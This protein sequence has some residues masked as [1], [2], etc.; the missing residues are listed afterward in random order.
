MLQSK[1]KG[2]I[3]LSKKT[4]IPLLIGA[5]ILIILSVF[6]IIRDNMQGKIASNDITN[7]ISSNTPSVKSTNA[8]I[9]TVDI[10]EIAA[11]ISWIFE[12]YIVEEH[13]LNEVTSNK[14]SLNVNGQIFKIGTYPGKAEEVKD[15]ATYDM[16][17]T[18]LAACKSVLQ[19]GGDY[20]YVVRKDNT[21]LSVMVRFM[22]DAIE[23]ADN[24][25]TVYTEKI[26]I[27]IPQPTPETTQPET[28][29]PQTT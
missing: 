29:Q 3:I 22:D 1:R 7:Q 8:P 18:T 25:K 9:P 23:K 13:T 15:F 28:Q 4:Y 26:V 20:F 6:F 10:K 21:S 12:G 2:A 5:G 24:T 17:T 11:N 14:I 27:Q 16:P 19:T